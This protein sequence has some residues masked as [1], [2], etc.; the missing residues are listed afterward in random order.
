MHGVFDRGLDAG[1]A[2]GR[3]AA[4]CSVRVLSWFGLIGFVAG[5]P[6]ILALIALGGQLYPPRHEALDTAIGYGLRGVML[7]SFIVLWVE[8]LDNVLLWERVLVRTW[9]LFIIVE[10]ALIVYLFY[11]S[12][13]WNPAVIGSDIEWRYF[14][15]LHAAVMVLCFYT[16]AGRV[17]IWMKTLYRRGVIEGRITTCLPAFLLMYPVMV[18]GLVASV[19]FI[20]GL[21]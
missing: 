11:L 15:D 10:M 13:W 5:P 19:Y 2:F 7:L 14:F 9:I 6:I 4:S 20:Y 16:I 3:T 1:E 17:Q 18:L 8:P 12:A 21:P